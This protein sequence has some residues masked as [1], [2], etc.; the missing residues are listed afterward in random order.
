M[1]I[2]FPLTPALN[3][4]WPVVSPIWRYDGTKWNAIAGSGVPG[5]ATPVTARLT[6]IVG[7]DDFIGLRA[8][9][10]YLVSASTIATYTGG[11]P[12]DTEP[13]AFSAGQWTAAATATA[14]EISFNLTT[15]PADGGSAITAL[16]YRVGAGAAI[17]FV[18]TGTGVRVVTAGLTA[19]TPVDLQ[20]RAV[21]AVGAGAWS[22]VKNRTPLAGGSATLV[23]FSSLTS[24]TETGNGTTGWIYTATAANGRAG[25]S[26]WNLALG[27]AG[28]FIVQTAVNGSGPLTGFYTGSTGTWDA[29]I[30]VIAYPSGADWFVNNAAFGD[31][32]TTPRTYAEGD[33]L[34]FVFAADN[35]FTVDIARS[36]A[37]TTWLALAAGTIT[38][39]ANLYPRIES[40][41]GAAA[42]FTAP[43]RV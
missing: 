34:R 10:P 7:T 28:T 15:L 21:N 24:M 23:R 14:G 37:P 26:D 43:Q 40:F 38:R 12:A 31:L 32:V 27:L 16:E 30:H 8:S 17:A 22:D 1:P 36:G 4:E 13:A 2:G 18:G 25:G 42:V 9:V 6:S 3:D 5:T 19:G 20:I 35:T 11:A 29:G 41:G 39:P 33:W